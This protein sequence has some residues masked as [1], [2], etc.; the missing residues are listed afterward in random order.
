MLTFGSK[1][2]FPF[3][4]LIR[5]NLGNKFPLFKRKHSLC[6]SAINVKT[7]EDD[8]SPLA[9]IR[10][11]DLT[12]IVAGPFCTMTLGDLGAEI[13]K[14][15]RPGTGDEARKWG[16]PYVGDSS[17]TC[18]FM[19]VNRNKKSI[20]VNLKS[21]RDVL[22]ELA[23]KCD[24]LVENYVPGK[25]DEFGLGYEDIKKVAPQLV[26][27]SLTGFGTVG[28]YSKRPG[29]DVIA[30]SIGGLLHIT[31]PTDGEP[32]KVG[33]AV[34]DLATGLYAHGAIM[35]ALLQRTRTGRG[36]KIDC[37]LLSTQVSCL[38]NVA[39]NYLNAGVETKRRGTAHESIVPYQ[40]F[41]TSDGEYVTVGAGSDKQFEGLCHKL[42]LKELTTDERFINNKLRVKN[43][44][45]LLKILYEQ[46][47]KKSLSEWL[48]LFDGSTFPYGPINSIEK[49]CL[50]HVDCENVRINLPFFSN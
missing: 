8:G 4:I 25:L 13:I 30:A 17:E 33:V 49:V 22:Y 20:C 43:R 37:N 44:E 31:G 18:Y 46:F 10:I 23:A 14:I 2:C 27:C 34:V 21:G 36:Q 32:C 47:E 50:I 6:N 41:K 42:G 24:V 29:Y 38:I 11:L 45:T 12:R 9:G 1:F 16:P 35:A 26:Y 5:Y 39:S 40:A 19:S 48:K 3:G 15:E 7:S 28:P